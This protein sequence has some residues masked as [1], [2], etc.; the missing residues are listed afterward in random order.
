VEGRQAR[1]LLRLTEGE[2]AEIDEHTLERLRS[3][4]YAR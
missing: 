1:Q 3:L 4:G 2:A